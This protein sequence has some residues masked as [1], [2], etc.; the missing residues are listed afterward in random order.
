MQLSA[1]GSQPAAA[2][3]TYLCSPPPMPEDSQ[4]TTN[5]VD[6]IADA[7]AAAAAAAAEVV[8]GAGAGRNGSQQEDSYMELDSVPFTSLAS[9]RCN[10]HYAETVWEGTAP[11]AHSDEDNIRDA[12]GTDDL[13][14]DEEAET[15]VVHAAEAATHQAPT[16]AVS[17]GGTWINSTGSRGAVASPWSG[18]KTGMTV[19]EESPLVDKSAELVGSELRPGRKR[20]RR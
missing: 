17:R 15:E 14:Y 11:D 1:G 12:N 19:V 9:K 16:P 10:R 2:A 5:G 7:E 18:V 6:A 4:E 8:A 13:E 20:T 3:Q